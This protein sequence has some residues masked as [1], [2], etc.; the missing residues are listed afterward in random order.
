[1]PE[2]ETQPHDFKILSI[3]GGG[4]KGLYSAIVLAHLEEEFGCK[5][6]D[7]FDM[8]CGTSTGGLIALGL[9][10]G[11]S[12]RELATFYE[13]E[14]PAIFGRRNV[15]TSLLKQ[16]TGTFEQVL[17]GGKYGRRNLEDAIVKVLGADTMMSQAQTLLCI[18]SFNLMK[19][20]PR[21]FK[22]PHKEGNIHATKYGRMVDVALATTAAPTYFPIASIED[23]Y[24]VDGGVWANNPTLCGVTEALRYFVGPGKLLKGLN[25]G[26]EFGRYSVLSVGSVQER[27]GWS[28]KGRFGKK[29]RKRSF[30][31]WQDKLFQTSLDGQAQFAHNFTSKLIHWTQVPGHYHRIESPHLSPEQHQVIGLDKASS[32]AISMLK[33]LGRQVGEDYRSDDMIGLVAPFFLHPKQYLTR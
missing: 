12:A 27:A 14:G 28:T 26:K 23:T 29:W 13:E 17:A 21:V 1:M 22:F 10:S 19:G 4:I 9:A 31:D 11:K 25:A 7:Y 32:S 16:L 8:I 24:Y 30:F 6:A 5:L 3:D 20:K 2:T 15:F 33:T 18:P